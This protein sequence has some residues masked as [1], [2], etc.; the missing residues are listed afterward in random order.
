MGVTV[1]QWNSEDNTSVRQPNRME[2]VVLTL[3]LRLQSTFCLSGEQPRRTG[4]GRAGQEEQPV[5][6]RAQRQDGGWRGWGHVRSGCFHNAVVFGKKKRGCGLRRADHMPP[7]PECRLC[8]ALPFIF[9]SSGCRCCFRSLCFLPS[10][11]VAALFVLFHPKF[12]SLSPFLSGESHPHP[13]PP[14]VFA[15]PAACFSF[16]DKG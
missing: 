13:H 14:L 2:L 12:S 9:F 1:S 3:W 7:L 6:F 5:H 16:P 11:R 4:P 8:S 10:H 15:S